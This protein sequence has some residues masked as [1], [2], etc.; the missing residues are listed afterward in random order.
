MYKY[1]NQLLLLD[2]VHKMPQGLQDL[3]L[4]RVQD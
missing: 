1:K 2:L 3:N 4:L